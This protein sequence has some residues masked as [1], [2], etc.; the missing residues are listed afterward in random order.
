[1]Q[2]LRDIVVVLDDSPASAMRLDLAVALAQQHDAHLTGFSALDL[3]VPPRTVTQPRVPPL[4][5][6]LSAS[7]V[8][9]WSS[10]TVAS[11]PDGDGQA[12][13]KAEGIEARFRDRLRSGALR[14]EWCMTDGNV[15][16]A[17]VSRARHADLVILGQVD[18]DHPPPP[19]GRQLAE[20]VLMTSGSPILV[21]PYI[22]RFETC[23]TKVLIGWNN[24]REAARA[25]SDAMPM[26]AKAS[27]ITILEASPVARKQAANDVTCADVASHL[28]HH[29]INARS[30]RT[31]LNGIAASDILLSYAADLTADLLVV[32]GYGHSRLRELILGGVTRG[33]LQHMTLPV[34][35]SH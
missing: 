13:E 7:Q 17:V 19:Q 14:G 15:S 4:L 22:G 33:L 18:P 35:M 31:V 34:L 9:N 28:A 25:V 3:L 30:A 16:E 1:M 5:D 6:T 23:G 21:V 27:S 24:S 12:A 20:D 11:Y 10:V 29:G 8:L 2:T 26:L 32:G